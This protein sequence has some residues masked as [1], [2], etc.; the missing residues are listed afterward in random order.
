MVNFNLVL[1]DILILNLLYLSL[2]FTQQQLLIPHI[3]TS[4]DF[5]KCCDYLGLFIRKKKM[6]KYTISFQRPLVVQV[7]R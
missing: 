6:Q 3:F 4:G 5:P 7:A 2:H 1:N